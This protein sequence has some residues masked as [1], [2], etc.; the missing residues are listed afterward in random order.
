MFYRHALNKHDVLLFC[1]Q[2]ICSYVLW[3]FAYVMGV[4]YDDCRQVAE[5]VGV[6]IFINE[7]VAY[8]DLGVLIDNSETFNEYNGTWV[9]VNDDIYLP[10]TNTTLVGGV[11]EVSVG[12]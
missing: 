12:T 8:S 9:K 1:V 3:P 11:M 4:A 2:L 5:L 6:K 10:D 7:F